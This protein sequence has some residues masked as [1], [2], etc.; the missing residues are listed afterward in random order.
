M[1]DIIQEKGYKHVRIAEVYFAKDDKILL[2]FYEY[3]ITF[4]SIMNLKMLSKEANDEAINLLESVPSSMNWCVEENGD[5]IVI[6]PHIDFIA[7]NPS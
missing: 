7:K 5:L 4:G 6:D 3:P 1:D 2:K